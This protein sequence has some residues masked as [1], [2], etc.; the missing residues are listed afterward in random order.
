MSKKTDVWF[1]KVRGSY[2]PDSWQ[3]WLTYV[4]FIGYLVISVFV[5]YYHSTS[6]GEMLFLIFPQWVATAVVM[7]W[8]A[9]HKS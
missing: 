7:Q 1:K 2:L 8:I 9:D 6:Y 5:A 4:P 3:G